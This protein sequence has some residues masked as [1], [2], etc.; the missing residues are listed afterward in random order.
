M[1]SASVRPSIPH[2][3]NRGHSRTTWSTA[4]TCPCTAKADIYSLGKVLYEIST[5]KDRH[6]YPE[7]PAELGNTA[8]DRDLIQFNKIVLKA[9]RANPRLRYK[10]AEE[11]MSALLA[12]QFCR[13]DPRREKVLQTSVQVIGTV[14]ILIA[15]GVITF[16]ILRIIWFLRHPS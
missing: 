7:L 6:D 5:G 13:H 12:F 15:I 3:T 8:E 9:C 2:N 14:G 16:L 4:G 11:M 1:M 10:S